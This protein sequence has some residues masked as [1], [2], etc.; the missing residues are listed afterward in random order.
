M[1]QMLLPLFSQDITLINSL[2]GYAKR[3]GTVY[4]FNGQMPLFSHHEKDE[5]SFKVFMAQLYVNGNATQAEINR[6]FG[7]NKI[8]MKRWAKKYREEGPGAFYRKERKTKP[9]VMTGK[10]ISVAQ[11]MLDE[12]Y[13]TFEAARELGIKVNTFGKAM[14][15]GRL[16]KRNDIK[17]KTFTILTAKASEAKKTRKHH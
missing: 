14:R 4:Y 3:N 17:K 9:R 16:I 2:I 7:M 1:P 12:G 6:A 11:S 5:A 8:N 15:D 10:V 13:E